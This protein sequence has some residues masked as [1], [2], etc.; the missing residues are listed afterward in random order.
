MEL[1]EGIT[2]ERIDIDRQ[3]IDLKAREKGWGIIKGVTGP[4]I[5]FHDEEGALPEIDNMYIVKLDS[6]KE[7]MVYVAA[8]VLSDNFPYNERILVGQKRKFN[9]ITVRDGK[10]YSKKVKSRK[11]KS[12]SKR[13][14]RNK[15]LFMD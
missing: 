7:I 4:F 15:K 9:Q 14:P 2:S 13:R 3:I 11:K 8:Y 5:Y 6:G 10:K 12:L 1:K